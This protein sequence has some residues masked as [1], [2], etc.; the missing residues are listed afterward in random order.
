MPSAGLIRTLGAMLSKVM[1]IILKLSSRLVAFC[2][3]VAIAASASSVSDHNNQNSTKG[4]EQDARDLA[5][6]FIAEFV[7]TKDLAP[8]V[9]HLYVNDFIQRFNNYKVKH[10][11]SS[12]D[13][14]FIPGLEYERALLTQGTVEDWRR[15]YIS[16]NTFFFYGFLSLAA[17]APAEGGDISVNDIYP[18]RVVELLNKNPNLANVIQRQGRGK[19]I[20]SIEELR[21]ATNTFEQAIAIMRKEVP[22]KPL[23]RNKLVNAMKDDLFKPKVE[24]MGDEDFFGVPKNSEVIYMKTPILFFLMLTRENHQLKILYAIPYVGD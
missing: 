3:V 10:P 21:N 18:G 20:S 4:A 14:Y 6:Q 2:L 19:A 7:G 23:D 15:F 11:D 9:E 17:K 24:V 1:R 5:V 16:E 8:V 12:F 22:I 13:L